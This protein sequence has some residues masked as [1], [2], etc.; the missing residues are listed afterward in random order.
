[1]G[2]GE[3]TGG[4]AYARRIEWQPSKTETDNAWLCRAACANDG[5]TFLADID[6]IADATEAFQSWCRYCP[7]REACRNSAQRHRWINTGLWG[8]LLGTPNGFVDVSNRPVEANRPAN[9]FERAEDVPPDVIASLDLTDVK[10]A[11]LSLLDAGYSATVAGRALGV[12]R[13]QV[14]GWRRRARSRSAA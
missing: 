12:T 5:G 2:I 13:D 11:A 7:V 3:L 9:L 14:N 4:A 1:M 6:S 8:G 10:T